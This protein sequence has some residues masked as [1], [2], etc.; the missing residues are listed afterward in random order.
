LL[1]LYLLHTNH[2]ESWRTGPHLFCAQLDQRRRVGHQLGQFVSH[3]VLNEESAVNSA[4]SSLERL[5]AGIQMLN[6]KI[7]KEEKK[8]NTTGR[9]MQP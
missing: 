2:R 5:G 4:A 9:K 3:P 8:N 1:R 6:E 7:K